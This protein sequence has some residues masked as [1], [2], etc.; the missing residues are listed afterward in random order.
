MPPYYLPLPLPLLLP[1][2]PLRVRVR[3]RVRVRVRVVR[4]PELG[5][6]LTA[7]PPVVLT[8]AIEGCHVLTPSMERVTN[9]KAPLHGLGLE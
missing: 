3:G 5:A 6:A 9:Q 2:P 8:G 7:A 4:S 1:L